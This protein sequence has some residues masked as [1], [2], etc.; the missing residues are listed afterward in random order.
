[1]AGSLD[2]PYYPLHVSQIS[3]QMIETVQRKVMYQETVTEQV[4]L[5]KTKQ[6]ERLNR[7]HCTSFHNKIKN[8]NSPPSYWKPQ[9]DRLRGF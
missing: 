9:E 6:L 3:C 8:V 2:V 1:M 7:K 5:T 4:L